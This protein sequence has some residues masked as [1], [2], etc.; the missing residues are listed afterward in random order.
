MKNITH[1]ENY[2]YE[3]IQTDFKLSSKPKKLYTGSF[4]KWVEFESDRIQIEKIIRE[5]LSFSL[6][7]EFLDWV[8]IYLHS[9]NRFSVIVPPVETLEENQILQKKIVRILSKNSG[10]RKISEGPVTHE[11]FG[12]GFF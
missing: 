1:F 6:G 11:G 2:G 8:L 7:E 10:S 3:D 12:I 9:N 5:I 4:K